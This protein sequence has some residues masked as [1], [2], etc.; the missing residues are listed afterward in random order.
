MSKPQL[1][2]LKSDVLLFDGAP[3]SM[4]ARVV[5]ESGKSTPLR[6][7]LFENTVCFPS[8]TWVTGSPPK[9]PGT[10]SQSVSP[11]K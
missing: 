9:E 8:P 3:S 11:P 4:V 10:I 2:R 5:T 6:L 1:D 7:L